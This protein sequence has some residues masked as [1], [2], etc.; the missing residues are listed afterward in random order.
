MQLLG[1]INLSFIESV[2][3]SYEEERHYWSLTHTPD[4]LATNI[5]WMELGCILRGDSSR[6]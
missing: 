6:L 3:V 5:L 2:R 1:Y 4:T